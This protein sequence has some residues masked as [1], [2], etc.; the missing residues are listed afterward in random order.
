MKFAGAI[1]RDALE[2]HAD[3]LSL[4]SKVHVIGDVDLDH[5]PATFGSPEARVLH[6]ETARTVGK[7]S[8][9]LE[10]GYQALD[11]LDQR[12]LALKFGRGLTIA[13]VAGRLGGSAERI[14]KR[15]QRVKAR[16]R[17]RL[18]A[19]SVTLADIQ[20]ALEGQGLKLTLFGA[21]LTELDRQP[22][23]QLVLVPPAVPQ[24]EVRDR[25]AF[26][27]SPDLLT[28]FERLPPP[29]SVRVP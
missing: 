3:K 26:I 7:V 9:A 5:R 6:D 19:E 21:V 20:A 1:S 11:L 14:Q 8:A 23:D 24:Q 10:R 4:A 2:V 17:S 22:G 18:E 12:I 13:Q 28:L 16:L 15:Y 29:H 25:E 27:L